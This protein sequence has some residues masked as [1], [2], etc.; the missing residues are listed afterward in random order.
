MRLARNKMEEAEL[1]ASEAVKLRDEMRKAMDAAIDE[2]VALK[3]EAD[4]KK[5]HSQTLQLEN[6]N[7]RKQLQDYED[8]MRRQKKQIKALN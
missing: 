3:I 4:E 6:V 5:D 1:S 8:D 7:I 2:K